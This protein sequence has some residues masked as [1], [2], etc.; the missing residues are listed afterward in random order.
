M[1]ARAC[2]L[3]LA[4]GSQLLAGIL[5]EAQLRQGR[6]L[7][8]AAQWEDL[9][10][11]RAAAEAYAEELRQKA[12]QRAAAKTL[13]ERFPHLTHTSSTRRR[14]VLR[15]R[16]VSQDLHHAHNL[17]TAA[18]RTRL[19]SPDEK[20]YL[21][22]KPVTDTAGD[23]DGGIPDLGRFE[24]EAV[25]EA[26]RLLKAAP[27]TTEIVL[28]DP[29]RPADSTERAR[30]VTAVTNAVEAWLIK[31]KADKVQALE[32]AR[33]ARLREAEAERQAAAAAFEAGLWGLEEREL[34][35]LLS[36]LVSDPAP[37]AQADQ[38]RAAVAEHLE[39]VQA[40]QVGGAEAYLSAIRREEAETERA[41]QK[42]LTGLFRAGR[43]YGRKGTTRIAAA[44]ELIARRGGD[45]ER[46]GRLMVI[47]GEMQ[48]AYGSGGRPVGLR[49]F[50]ES[51]CTGAEVGPGREALAVVIRRIDEAPA[52]QEMLKAVREHGPD[53]LEG[54]RQAMVRTL[55]MYRRRVE[56]LL[57]DQEF[58]RTE[59]GRA[60][61]TQAKEKVAECVGVIEQYFRWNGLQHS[62]EYAGRVE[63]AAAPHAAR[64][65]AARQAEADKE[66]RADMGGIVKENHVTVFVAAV[67]ADLVKG[68]T[69]R[70][71]AERTE[72][73]R[74][75][76]ALLPTFTA[77]AEKHAAW[78]EVYRGCAEA[79]RLVEREVTRELA[80]RD[81]A[82]HDWQLYQDE[83]TERMQQ[84]F[85]RCAPRPADGK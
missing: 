18:A 80:A 39:V 32:E 27:G 14:R 59:E 54:R 29:L 3:M 1:D 30:K 71:D 41:K 35:G 21:K 57:R 50:L 51:K 7:D 16:E 79:G 58:L 64:Q 5:P 8:V 67:R 82:E 49:N 60:A 42:G 53:Y 34:T 33:Q 85:P 48:P 72:D 45:V 63:R 17:E 44:E 74:T 36:S 24:P 4:L 2:G 52:V 68:T 76:L 70:L 75:M 83:Q 73:L 31:D 37:Q 26:H 77:A 10:A 61:L 47:R 20:A 66:F 62:A 28:R 19:F 6:L 69:S 38:R 78:S 9:D 84:L 43:T 65:L 13:L 56:T 55:E 15:K 46:M 40:A 25:A 22:A 81:R 11:F 23:A 12:A